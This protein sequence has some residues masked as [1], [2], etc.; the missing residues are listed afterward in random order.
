LD[1]PFFI[2]GLRMHFTAVAQDIS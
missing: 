2:P 1:P